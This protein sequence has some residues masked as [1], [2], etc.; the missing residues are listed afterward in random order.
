MDAKIIAGS[1]PDGSGADSHLDRL[2]APANLA[3]PWH[4]S[5]LS[6]LRELVSPQRLP[7][8]EVTS[9]PVAVQDIWG[10]Y[11]RQ[12]KSFIFSLALQCGAVALLFM[13]LSNPTVQTRVRQ[14]ATLVLPADLTAPL[15][16]N[17]RTASGG[18]GGGDRSPLP[19]S[20][21]RL[22]KAALRQFVPPSAVTLNAAAKLTMEPSIIAPPDVS[23]PNVN[24]ANY[25]DPLGRLGPASNGPGSG[26]GIGSGR[27]GGVGSGTGAGV[28]PG[29][30]GGFGGG[31]FSVGGGVSPPV[32]LYRPDPEYSDEARKAKLQGVVVVEVIVDEHGRVRDPKILQSLGLGL[33]EEAV[34]SV[35]TWKFK[36]AMRAGRPVAVTID[37]HT[38]FRLL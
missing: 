21:G 38:T 36:P 31:V 23:L 1:P 29:E 30:G 9:Q 26:G 12:K 11:G 6:N 10:L 4:R 37:V 13:A 28:G 3:L 22:P 14:V 34:K 18:G 8:I 16:K 19:A 17:P 5:L 32:P 27:G 20:K 2:L 15:P 24:M 33:D 7:P 35:L 25:G